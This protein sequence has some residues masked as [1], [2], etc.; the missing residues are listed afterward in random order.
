[1]SRWGLSH[2]LGLASQSLVLPNGLLEP[3]VWGLP[4]CAPS[5]LEIE[6]AGI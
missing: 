6:E 4:S 1:M 2:R 5:G 3:I